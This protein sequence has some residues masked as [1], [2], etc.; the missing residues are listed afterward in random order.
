MHNTQ[1]SLLPLDTISGFQVRPGLYEELGANLIPG[2]VSF[3]VHS[4]LAASCELL[5][6]HHEASE[7]Y[8]RIPIPK[9]YRIGNVYSIIVFDLDIRDLEY[10]FCLDGPCD[11]K[12]GICF[13]KNKYLLDPY[14]RAVTG[15]GRCCLLYTS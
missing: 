13:D 1:N 2:G 5:L 4:Q 12:K 3:T 7:P 9:H 8:A 11:E 15:Q 10:A 14:A 6:F